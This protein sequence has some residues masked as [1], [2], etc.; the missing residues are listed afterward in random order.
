MELIS[1]KHLP[2]SAVA[3]LLK[4]L[5]ESDEEVTH[6]VTRVYE[7]ARKVGKCLEAD[8]LVNEISKL[9]LNEIT[10]VIIVNNC[11][12]D[13]NELRILLNFESKEPD[14]GILKKVLDVIGECCRSK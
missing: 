14:E 1:Y 6:M 12:K 8:E 3:K 5:M 4:G 13:L 9:G 10:S 11:P 2:Y 7:Y